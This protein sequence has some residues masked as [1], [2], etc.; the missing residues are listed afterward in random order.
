MVC[1]GCQF[2]VATTLASSTQKPSCSRARAAG[3][4]QGQGCTRARAALVLSSCRARAAGQ[5]CTRARAALVLGSCRAGLQSKGRARGREL[6]EGAKKHTNS[7][8][9]CVD[10]SVNANHS[11]KTRHEHCLRFSGCRQHHHERRCIMSATVRRTIKTH[12]RQPNATMPKAILKN[13]LTN[14]LLAIV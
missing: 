9:W 6:H 8:S 5:G 2:T 1:Y 4:G 13:S 7:L 11:R 14:Q 10:V 12:R 3:Q